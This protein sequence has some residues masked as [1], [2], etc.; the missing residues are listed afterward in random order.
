MPPLGII[1]EREQREGPRGEKDFVRDLI[2]RARMRH[3]ADH[4]VMMIGPVGDREAR[5]I[6]GRRSAPFGDDEQRRR[7]PRAV[8]EGQ[9]DA[10]RVD[11]ARD[12]LRRHE[13]AHQ[14]RFGK[15][16]REREAKLAVFDHRTERGGTRIGDE[17]ELARLSPVA[18]LDR[19]DR[20]AVGRKPIGKAEHAEHLPHRAGDRRGAAVEAGRD[21]RNRIGGVDDLRR[22]TMMGKRDRQRL[23]D[24]PAAGDQ[25]IAAQYFAHAAALLRPA[26]LG[27][28]AGAR[29]P[30]ARRAPLDDESAPCAYRRG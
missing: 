9:R 6:A 19:A 14:R 26:A 22:Q 3:R 30:S 27:K 11:I 23:A 21:R 25:D 16:R 20:A 28:R 8:G 17:I 7:E 10:M 5:R 29:G 15:R 1:D 18:D 2:V 12:H 13:Q 24:K 4:R